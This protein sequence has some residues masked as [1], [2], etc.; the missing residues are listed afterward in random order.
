MG[1]DGAILYL[2]AMSEGR[3]RAVPMLRGVYYLEVPEA[4]HSYLLQLVKELGAAGD[5]RR[6]KV[7]SFLSTSDNLYTQPAVGGLDARTET[8]LDYLLARDFYEELFAPDDLPHEPKPLLIEIVHKYVLLSEGLP[9]EEVPNFRNAYRIIIGLPYLPNGGDFVTWLAH[10]LNL[11]KA[12]MDID[13]SFH[14]LLFSEAWPC[15]WEA[16]LRFWD[17]KMLSD[18]KLA[19][20]LQELSL[21][22]I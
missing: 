6:C 16:A 3:T 10:N 17:S 21:I 1:R 11:T 14:I 19:P 12:K 18:A 15:S 20:Y 4:F 8:A 22:H 9:P 7:H 13:L 5:A 2:K